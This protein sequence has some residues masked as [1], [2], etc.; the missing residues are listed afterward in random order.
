MSELYIYKNITNN[1]TTPSDANPR[2]PKTFQT[3][4]FGLL[5]AAT[6]LAKA[7][8]AKPY[9][10]GYGQ[11]PWMPLKPFYNYLPSISQLWHPVPNNVY[12]QYNQLTTSLPHIQPPPLNQQQIIHIHETPPLK[13]VGDDIDAIQD[14]TH[15]QISTNHKI[16]NSNENKIPLY[17]ESN[18]HN[19]ELSLNNSITTTEGELDTSAEVIDNEA[20]ASNFTY[21]IVNSSSGEEENITI[22]TTISPEEL[23]SLTLFP[24]IENMDDTVTVSTNKR[25]RRTTPRTV[26]RRAGSRRPIHDY[27]DFRSGNRRR[28]VRRRPTTP[29]YDYIFDK[30]SNRRKK[31]PPTKTR[32]RPNR[33]PINKEPEFYD[34]DYRD[35]E[36]EYDDYYPSSVNILARQ[37]DTTVTDTS[38]SEI[39][40]ITTGSTI[41]TT[42]TPPISTQGVNNNTNGYTYGPP[43]QSGYGAP[44][45]TGYGPSNGN[46]YISITYPPVSG[47]GK[48]V[49]APLLDNLYNQYSK[50][51]IIR[52]LQELLQPNNFY[53]N[54]Q[55]D[56]NYPENF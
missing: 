5:V 37:E 10:L 30:Q 7:S 44:G 42:T 31:R 2:Q 50:N 13:S 20:E 29:T 45:Q 47:P 48:D 9:L 8:Q 34:S 17:E 23:E 53:N 56:V 27:D 49:L 4:L 38:T 22:L 51:S 43:I 40:T 52:R 12:S 26:I 36:N 33:R 19:V 6:I 46:E 16:E 32:N 1:S 35:D 11:T 21:T 18:I 41:T 39:S 14:H 3:P 15:Q 28:P 25:S 55:Y 24:Q 54:Q